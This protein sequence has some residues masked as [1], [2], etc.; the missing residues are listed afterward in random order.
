ML[1]IIDYGMGN[2]RSVYMA[3]GRLGVEAEI[4]ADPEKVR[5]AEALIFPGVGA[6]GDAMENIRTRG[7]DEAMAS[8]I[9]AGCPFLGICLGLQ[10]LFEASDEMG[11][12]RGLGILPGRVRRFP[13]GMV[14][15]HMG[16]NQL[17][18]VR[19]IPLWRGIPDASYAY[20]VHSYYVDPE[21]ASVVAATTDYG[22]SYVSAVARDNV[23]GI[24]CHPEKSQDVGARILRNFVVEAGLLE[25]DE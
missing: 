14:V 4:T 10:L 16:W 24:Q 12:H 22:I 6:F 7:L 25:G 3:L 17:H 11:E 13:E 20:F 21:D 23:Y 2:L 15:P 8:V 19:D 5:C 1:T 9:H 18:Q